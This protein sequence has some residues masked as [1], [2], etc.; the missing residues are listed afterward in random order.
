LN[1]YE[2]YLFGHL[3]GVFLLLAAAGIS[4][5]SGIMVAR[6]T[7]ANVALTLLRLMRFSEYVVTS[8]GAVLVVVFGILLV[9]E[10]DYSMG[11][12]WISGAFTLLIVILAIDHGYLMPQAKKA[13]RMAEALGDGPVS[14]ELSDH[15]NNP[16]TIAA[17]ALLDV[18]FLVFLFLMIAKPGA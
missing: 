16:L 4:T 11:D 12:P 5:A 8:A 3:L 7:A 15:L 6:V 13:A 1:T 14:K 9:N 10:A 2:V 17:G 18:S